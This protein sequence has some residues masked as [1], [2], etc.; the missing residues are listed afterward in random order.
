MG[1]KLLMEILNIDMLVNY[2][3]FPIAWLNFIFP[4]I[5]GVGNILALFQIC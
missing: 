3:F 5:F 2:D 1:I 4:F